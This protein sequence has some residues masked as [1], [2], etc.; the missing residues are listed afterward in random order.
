M[1]FARFG[2]KVFGVAEGDPAA[3]AEEGIRRYRGWLGELGMPLTLAE[4][5]AK[6]GDIPALVAKLG[7]NGS[8]LGSFVPLTEADVAQILMRCA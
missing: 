6:V 5:G 4:L 3:M 8:T 2:A 7:L 1:R